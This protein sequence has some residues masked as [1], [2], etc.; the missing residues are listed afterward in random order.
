MGA[1]SLKGLLLSSCSFPV[2]PGGPCTMSCARGAKPW[3]RVCIL[4]FG[5]P[6]LSS[7]FKYYKCLTGVPIRNLIARRPKPGFVPTRN[8][9]LSIRKS[10]PRNSKFRCSS[11]RTGILPIRNSVRGVRISAGS[12]LKPESTPMCDLDLSVLFPLLLL[13]TASAARR[14]HA[15]D[16]TLQA[17]CA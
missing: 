12:R 14:L 8:H 15:R 6:R 17:H 5:G 1:K 13:V 10:C 7:P 3:Q 4:S 11:S 16:E 9:F 2:R